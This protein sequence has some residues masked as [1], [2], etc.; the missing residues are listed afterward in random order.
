M[1]RGHYLPDG[2]PVP[3]LPGI[4]FPRIWAKHYLVTVL[5][6]Q[7]EVLKIVPRPSIKRFKNGNHLYARIP[8]E[9][10]RKW[11]ENPTEKSIPK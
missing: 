1:H 2:C 7:K 9:I 10:N 5:L 4:I 6:P 3:S 8:S 11:I